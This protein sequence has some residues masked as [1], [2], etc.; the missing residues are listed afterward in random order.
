MPPF[1]AIST[2]W[3]RACH[4]LR[5]DFASL[6]FPLCRNPSYATEYLMA[7]GFCFSFHLEGSA[8]LLYL[9]KNISPLPHPFSPAGGRWFETTG[10]LEVISYP[11]R[12]ICLAGAPETVLIHRMLYMERAFWISFL[13]DRRICQDL[14]FSSPPAPTHLTNAFLLRNVVPYCRLSLLELLNFYPL[15]L[16]SIQLLHGFSHSASAR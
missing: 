11:G 6:V 2:Q 13:E 7:P 1:L 16:M 5:S 15:L 3:E 9:K 10:E 12:L 8:F 14:F 4:P